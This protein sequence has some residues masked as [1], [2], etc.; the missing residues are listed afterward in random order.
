MFAHNARKRKD[1]TRRAV[2]PIGFEG[3]AT[4][5]T[6]SALKKLLSRLRTAN[7]N[8]MRLSEADSDGSPTL[9]FEKK[10]GENFTLLAHVRQGRRRLA[11]KSLT[12]ER[13]PAA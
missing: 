3:M 4:V 1:R 10:L 2:A 11:V 7:E 9:F 6:L 12:K 13:S 8:D 5:G